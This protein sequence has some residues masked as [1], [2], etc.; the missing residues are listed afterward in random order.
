MFDRY[1]PKS[2]VV[3]VDGSQAAIR[4]A[5]WAVDEVA[6]TDIPLRLLY[7]TKANPGAGP[8]EARAALMAAEEVVHDA[9]NAVDEMGRQLKVETEVLHGDPVPELIAASRSTTLLCVGDTGAAQHP[10]AWLG[11]TAKELA[12]SGHCSVVI[13]RGDLHDTGVRGGGWIVA[14]VDESPDGIDVLELA[15]HEARHRGAPLRVLTAAQS[16]SSDIKTDRGPVTGDSHLKRCM[17]T[18]PEVK[19]DTVL[20]EGSFL[21]YLVEHATSIQLVMVGAART[22]EVQQL[23]GGAGAHA[24]RDSDFSLLVVGLQ[25][26]GR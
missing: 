14:L 22:G 13:V 6:G 5:R 16:R 8:G 26:P 10:D 18:Y 1:P 15:I 2:V 25:R 23:L 12:Q 3:G 19:I 17:D 24:L 11:S 21:D 4:A 9:C 20:L 7:I